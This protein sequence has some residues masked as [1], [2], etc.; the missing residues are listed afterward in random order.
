MP[1]LNDDLVST[2][3]LAAH[4][5]DVRVVDI[6][7]YVRTEDLGGGR[8]KASYSGARDEYDAGHIPGSVF[9]DWT[10][11]ITD[12]DA[13]VKA[14][15]APP[16]VFRARME[17]LG[18]GDGTPV[19][20]VDHTGGH[21]ATRLWWALRYY[22]H[23]EVAVL[24]GGFQRWKADGLPVDSEPV[25]V[26]SAVFT[27]KVRAE[28]RSDAEDVLAL[29][30]SDTRQI[31]DARDIATYS[32]EPQ[33]GTRGGHI[34]G[35]VKLPAVSL[36]QADGTW[37]TPEEI[38]QIAEAAGIDFSQGVTAYCNGGVTA[39]AAMFGLQRAGLTDVSNYD[40]SWNE[41]GERP[42]LPV[43]GNR[44]LFSGGNT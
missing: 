19:V 39:T 28:L 37:K 15:I 20:V 35:A 24:D 8:Q 14:Q 11:D 31:V 38:R 34:P 22:G 43:E 12:P 42:E 29:L 30:G 3:W 27:P 1:V 32:G 40:G 13:T 16:D 2:E 17:S 18:I 25:T 5:A 10:A 7:G 21:M 9:V 26:E 36:K 33:R 4:L 6:R 41:W 44:D 23:D